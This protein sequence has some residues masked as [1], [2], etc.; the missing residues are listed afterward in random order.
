VAGIPGVWAMGLKLQFELY[1]CLKL[2]LLK[3]ELFK[4]KFFILKSHNGHR[5]SK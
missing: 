3:L 1:D 5:Y 4:G 2:Y